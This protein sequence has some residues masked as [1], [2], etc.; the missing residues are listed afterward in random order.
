L[1]QLIAVIGVTDSL[2]NKPPGTR[3][4]YKAPTKLT[5]KS[6]F[7]D[8]GAAKLPEQYCTICCQVYN[9]CEFR[10]FVSNNGLLEKYGVTPIVPWSRGRFFSIFRCE[11]ATF[12]LT[13]SS[14]SI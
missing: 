2:L 3:L 8:L 14:T 1:W 10:R 4:P 13:D 11:S 9:N 6:I 12:Q 7:K 5:G